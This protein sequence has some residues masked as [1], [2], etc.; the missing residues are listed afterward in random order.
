[1]SF[2][3]EFKEDLSQAVNELVDEKAEEAVAETKVE[4]TAVSE[5][6]VA[7]AAE[8]EM[9]N[10]IDNEEFTLDVA[11]LDSMLE[12]VAEEEVAVVEEDTV[13]VEQATPEV[14]DDVLPSDEI[15][16]I[17]KGTSITGNIESDGSV[18]VYGKIVGD[19]TC[20][21]KLVVTGRINGTSH[22]REIFANNA[23]VEGDVHSD[24]TIKIG[25]GSVIVG[26][27]YATSAVIA[28]A[29]KGDI[30]VN[31]PVIVDGTA[32]VKGN[33]KSRSVQI[34]NGAVIDGFCSQSYADIDY[35]TLFEDTFS[36]N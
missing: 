8:E 26:N 18:N 21:G 6:E 27:V 14:E 34:N 35:K 20:K 12:E 10:T 29:V 17:T 1:M 23:K 3:K 13:E 31:G 7:P 19:I 36:M 33:I 11:E 30:D 9:I 24:G 32:V 28:G 5:P 16:E 22:A 25:N 15:A 4:E 2:L